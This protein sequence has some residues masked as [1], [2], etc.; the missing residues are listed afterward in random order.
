VVF[1]RPSGGLIRAN[2]N[3]QSRSLLILNETYD[4]GWQATINGQPAEIVRVNAV[5]QGVVLP[6][7]G[8]YQVEWRF[9]PPGLWAGAVSSLV[10]V[11]VLAVA[12]MVT[13]V[14]AMTQ[15]GRNTTNQNL[16]QSY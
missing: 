8:D 14:M 9:W 6:T 15:K 3:C 12:G 11:M 13:I 2:V 4:P 10:A 7:G 16:G 1:D 5:V